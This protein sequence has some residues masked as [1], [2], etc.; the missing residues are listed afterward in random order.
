MAASSSSSAATIAA[1]DVFAQQSAL[2]AD[3]AEAI[4]HRFDTCT[5]SLG[6]LRQPVFACL[7]CTPPPPRN[8]N[9]DASARKDWEKMAGICASCSVSCHGDHEQVELFNKRN[10]TCDCPTRR[11]HE[12]CK[13]SIPGSAGASIGHQ[14]EEKNQNN[15][16]GSNYWGRFC[17]CG[18]EYDPEKEQE[19]MVQCLACEV[20]AD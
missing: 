20:G 18:R 10:F 11:Y 8:L 3:A 17:R 4:P 16:Y 9:G 12:P 13:L 5:Y 19:T 15:L 2:I 7:T 14:K 1:A 6:P